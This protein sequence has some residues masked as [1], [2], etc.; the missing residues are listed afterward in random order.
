MDFA[1]SEEH[2][3]KI[4]EN[5]KEMQVLTRKLKILWTVTLFIIGMLETTPKGFVRELETIALLRPTR[6]L[7]WRLEE[8]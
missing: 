1:I 7:T 4:K 8:I 3:V 6:I 5:L 2:R